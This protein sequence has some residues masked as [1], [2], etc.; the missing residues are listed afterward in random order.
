MTAYLLSGPSFYL[1]GV[2]R[3][4]ASPLSCCSEKVVERLQRMKQ[5]GVTPGPL[6]LS[7]TWNPA[8]ACFLLH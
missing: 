3:G 1:H 7:Q 5:D 6:K 4:P 2:L 8:P